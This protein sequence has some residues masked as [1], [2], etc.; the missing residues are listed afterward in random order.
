[1]AGSHFHNLLPNMKAPVFN[2]MAIMPSGDI[3]KLTLN[4]Q[5][6]N[7]KF[8]LLVFYPA[9]WGMVD[10]S[11]V[12]A[13]SDKKK[14]FY[15]MRT[16]VVFIS[17]GS[18]YSHAEWIKTPSEEGG[19]GPIN[20]PLVSDPTHHNAMAYGVFKMDESMAFRATFLIDPRKIVRYISCQELPQGRVVKEQLRMVQAIQYYDRT[21]RH[22]GANWQVGIQGIRPPKNK[23]WKQDAERLIYIEQ[24]TEEREEM[25][26]KKRE[27]SHKHLVQN[28]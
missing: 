15:D 21:G 5:R 1:M 20:F 6:F 8:V 13:F 28:S 25:L 16:E 2:G 9:D 10:F 4:D 27:G 23:G 18:Q 11:E 7:G 14:D 17:C 12:T 3:E 19:L 22:C 24:R 26:R